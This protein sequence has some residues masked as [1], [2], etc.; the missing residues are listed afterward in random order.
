MFDQFGMTLDF[1]YA[2]ATIKWVTLS[3]DITT[4]PL[5]IHNGELNIPR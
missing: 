4:K 3:S 1:E 5:L 2:G